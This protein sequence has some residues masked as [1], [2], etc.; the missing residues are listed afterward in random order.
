MANEPWLKGEAVKGVDYDES[1]ELA[2]QWAL[3]DAE[4]R[5]VE[6]L[7]V[8]DATPPHG[9]FER[10]WM[11]RRWDQLPWSWYARQVRQWKKR[12]T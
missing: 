10:S 8:R 2:S 9:P 3:L 12:N 6:I 5:E 11:R 1:G 4:G 7:D